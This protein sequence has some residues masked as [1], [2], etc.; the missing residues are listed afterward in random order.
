MEKKWKVF[1]IFSS[2]LM[3]HLCLVNSVVVA[4]AKPK[5]KVYCFDDQMWVVRKDYGL[6]A[7]NVSDVKVGSYSN[8]WEILLKQKGGKKIME[9]DL[10]QKKG[11]IY[12][13]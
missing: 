13:L 6:I 9:V 7:R 4:E 1:I 5:E 3:L 12:K 10:F 11:N 8:L 2:I